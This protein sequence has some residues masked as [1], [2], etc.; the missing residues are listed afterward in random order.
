MIAYFMMKIL[1]SIGL[2]L[3][4]RHLLTRINQIEIIYYYLIVTSLLQI[5]P[6]IIVLNLELI[7]IQQSIIIIPILQAD[8]LIILP[9]LTLWM[10][11]LHK[12]LYGRYLVNFIITVIWT[13]SFIGLTILNKAMDVITF[14]GW[15]IGIGL[16]EM[17]CIYAL[18]I[19]F[20][21]IFQSILRKEM[22]I[23]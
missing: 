4:L 15:N 13:F 20:Y 9:I 12:K 21:I 10:L 3:T 1:V 2:I 22:D 14:H 17:L 11:Y 6:N 19:G 23:K 18:L 5:V 7:K 8:R 16:V